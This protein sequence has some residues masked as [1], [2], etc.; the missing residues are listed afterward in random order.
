M[1]LKSEKNTLSL[2]VTTCST[3]KYVN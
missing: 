2:Y 1:E 3:V